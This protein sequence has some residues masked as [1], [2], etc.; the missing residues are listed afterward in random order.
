[1]KFFNALMLLAFLLSAG[2]QYNDADPFLW[3]AIY[4]LGSAACIQHWKRHP[5]WKLPSFVAA[6]G[7]LWMGF[8]VPTLQNSEFPIIWDQV[9]LRADMKT[10]AVELTREIG[11]LAILVVWMIALAIRAYRFEHRSRFK[12]K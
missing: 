8:L 12:A 9:F 4:V 3:V 6:L 1:M 11:G 2:V 5:S 10:E 7:V